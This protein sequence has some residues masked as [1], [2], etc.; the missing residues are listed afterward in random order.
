MRKIEL[1]GKWVN[2]R[3]INPIEIEDLIPGDYV[4]LIGVLDILTS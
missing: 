3:N 2:L 1:L 4:I